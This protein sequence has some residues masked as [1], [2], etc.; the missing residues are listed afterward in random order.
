MRKRAPVEAVAGISFAIEAGER[1][2][3]IGPNGA[4]KSTSI[5]MLTGI[6]H[7]SSGSAEVLWL[8]PWRH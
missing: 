1:L 4:G 7:P 6:L 3:Y 8:V 5:K 2:A